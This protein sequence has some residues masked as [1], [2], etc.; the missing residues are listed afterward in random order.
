M[1]NFRLPA[2][3]VAASVALMGAATA[4][5]IAADDSMV[6]PP[7]GAILMAKANTSSST[8]AGDKL[9]TRWTWQWHSCWKAG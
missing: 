9:R 1:H 8:K 7:D 5:A 3:L 2:V 4:P 6:T